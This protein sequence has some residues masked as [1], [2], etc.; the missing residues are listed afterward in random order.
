VAIRIA[1]DVVGRSIL[2]TIHESNRMEEIHYILE[3]LP[4]PVE[5]LR[6]F[7]PLWKKKAA[8]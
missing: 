7:S 5:T 4:V 1:P 2:F 6:S 8:A 3:T